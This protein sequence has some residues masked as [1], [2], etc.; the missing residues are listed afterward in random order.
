MV[1]NGPIK[2]KTILILWAFL[3]FSHPAGADP[4]EGRLASLITSGGCMAMAG[5]QEIV[6]YGSTSSFIPAST[7]K[8]ATTL[9]ALETLGPL[10]AFK[11]EFYLRDHSIL[12][13]KG[14]GDPF[15]TSEYLPA[16]AA[17]LRQRGIAS[18]SSIILDDSFFQLEAAPDGSANSDN[19]YDALN[20]A[21]AVNF[22]AL[23]LVKSAAGEIISGEEQTPLL[24][25]M[26]EVGENL[27]PGSYRLNVSAFPQQGPESNILR[28]AAELFIALFRSGG[29]A[30]ADSW[31]RGTTDSADVLLYTHQSPKNTTEVVRSCLR[32]S[33]NFIANQLFLLSGAKRYGPPATWNKGRDAMKVFLQEKIGPG[34]EMLHLVEGSGL[35]SKN[36]ATPRAMIQLLQAF[37]PYASLLEEKDGVLLKSGTLSEVYNYAGYFKN[38]TALDPFIIL[39]NQPLNNRKEILF[40]LRQATT[41]RN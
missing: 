6:A 18:I 37:R 25:L 36:R 29:M 20:A 12:I 2:M 40:L 3:L 38:D 15:L 34:S 26:R 33:N 24:P 19:P 17:A 30:V 16:I 11:T 13:I 27:A 5:R 23:P 1:R 9:A 28:Y 7:I 22:N 10:H 39:L 41:P 4:V 21:L 8:I 31:Q 35:S 14:Y 32:Y